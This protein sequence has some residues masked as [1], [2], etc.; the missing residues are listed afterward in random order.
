[1]Q[2][3]FGVVERSLQLVLLI[4]IEFSLCEQ[5]FDLFT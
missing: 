5:F 3:A 4:P 2:R 1:M